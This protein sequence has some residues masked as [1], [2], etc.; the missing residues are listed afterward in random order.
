MIMS[1]VQFF[2]SKNVSYLINPSPYGKNIF[3]VPGGAL[4]PID[5]ISVSS[6]LKYIIVR[7][8]VC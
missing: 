5:I 7:G 4:L 6:L 1:S 2:M 8:I 3:Q